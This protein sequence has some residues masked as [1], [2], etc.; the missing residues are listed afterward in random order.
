M[1][2]LLLY[3]LEVHE[4][5]AAARW[6]C[7]GDILRPDETV[8]GE[9]KVDDGHQSSLK[10]LEVELPRRNRDDGHGNVRLK[11]RFERDLIHVLVCHPFHNP[12]KK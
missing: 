8:V 5:M 6:Q 10:H 1:T 12:T 4:R 7:E 9:F 3:H 2:T 11:R